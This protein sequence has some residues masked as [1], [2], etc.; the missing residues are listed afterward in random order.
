MK[1]R[2]TDRF[3]ESIKRQEVGRDTYSD[4]LRPGLHLRVGARKASWLFEKRIKGGKPRKHTLGAYCSWSADGQRSPIK[5]TLA[6]ARRLAIEIDAESAKGIDRVAIQEKKKREAEQAEAAKVALCT[7]LRRYEELKLKQ[8]R[9]GADR[10]RSLR[11]ALEPHLSAPVL[12]LTKAQLQAIIDDKATEGRLVF[13]NRIRSYLRA[14]T[15]WAAKRDYLP[16]DIG[17]D[18][19]GTG[20]EMPR[21]RVLSLGEM[22]CIFHSSFELG[23]LWGPMFRLLILTGQRRGEISTLR[24]D[25]VNLQARTITLSGQRTKNRRPHTTHLS[26]AALSVLENIERNGKFV[27]TTTSVTPSSGISKAKRKLDELLGDRVAPWRL[28]DVRRAMATALAEAGVPE[29]VVD[30]IQNHSAVGSAPSAVAR[31]YQQSDLL[32]QRA[33]ALDRWAEMIT[34]SEARVVKMGGV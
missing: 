33:A 32:P 18:L 21:D 1:K 28:H 4:T 14:F 10:S 24:W 15:N 25:E 6:E 5:M 17:K 19:E 27:F 23:P 3:L 9:T 34:E 31:V 16:I 13:A 11:N 26:P 8:L 2:L 7:V 29:G 12:N 22:R 20:T 30:R